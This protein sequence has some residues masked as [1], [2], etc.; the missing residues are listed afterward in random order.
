MCPHGYNDKDKCYEC[1]KLWPGPS[2][3]NSPGPSRS[4]SPGP[5]GYED[6]GEYDSPRRR[7]LDEPSNPPG[8]PRPKLSSH[9]PRDEWWKMYINPVDH[10]RA[11]AFNPDNPGS[12]YDH[13]GSGVHPPAPGWQE[14]MTSAYDSIL[15]DN[16]GHISTA[17]DYERVHLRATASIDPSKTR[18]DHTKWS[19]GST[20]F[21][22]RGNEISPDTMAS[23]VRGRTLALPLNKA[24][25]AMS[26]GKIGKDEVV[27]I[28]MNEPRNFINAY[29]T[30]EQAKQLVATA[31]TEYYW[32][33]E[34][35]RNRRERLEAIA[36]VIRNLQLI[37][38]FQDGNQRTNVQLLL[39]RFLLDQG[40]KPILPPDAIM[41]F[42]GAYSTAQIA[43]ALYRVQK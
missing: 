38:P 32:R 14:S 37:H 11:K 29:K 23:T 42:N 20:Q 21:P 4:N 24:L 35:T 13:K 25:S 41:L 39:V 2:R 22:L 1:I 16:P 26:S 31:L 8:D 17:A 3:Y 36:R 15:E 33:I 27:A 7:Y 6:R 9:A 5:P 12:L 40:F 43:E 18:S 28:L 19:S 30:E 34:Q 10:E